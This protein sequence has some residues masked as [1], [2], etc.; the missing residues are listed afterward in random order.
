MTVVADPRARC[1]VRRGD[2]LLVEEAFDPEAGERAFHPPGREVPPEQSAAEA[3]RRE[4][5]DVLD[6]ELVALTDLGTF[7]G[8]RVFEGE[9]ADGW[10]YA[11]SGFTVYDPES[12]ETTR[13]S[14]LHRDDFEK[15]GE[16]LRPEGLLDAL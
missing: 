11:E 16:T 14:W 3:V 10:L 4:F 2:E 9:A 13:L 15:Y 12:G 7:D 6:V 5:S 8:V 1:L